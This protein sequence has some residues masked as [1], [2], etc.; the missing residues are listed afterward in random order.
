MSKYPV[1]Y[2]DTGIYF[3]ETLVS[4]VRDNSAHN[5]SNSD[6]SNEDRLMYHTT[7]SNAT[8]QVLCGAASLNSFTVCI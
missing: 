8:S 7:T 3:V 1:V 2:L 6:I 5:L 4:R